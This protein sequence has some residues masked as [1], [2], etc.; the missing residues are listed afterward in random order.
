M[1][2][3]LQ[4]L[5]IPLKNPEIPSGDLGHKKDGSTIIFESK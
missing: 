3:H 1:A 2:G 5:A 4:V